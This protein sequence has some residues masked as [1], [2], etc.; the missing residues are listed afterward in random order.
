MNRNKR[1]GN[2]TMKHH[3]NGK[4]IPCIKGRFCRFTI[5]ELLVV[6]AIIAILAGMLLPALNKARTTAQKSVC[7]SNLKSIGQ[8][9]MIYTSNND[10]FLTPHMKRWGW[11]YFAADI[12]KTASLPVHGTVME[13]LAPFPHNL[14]LSI[15]F[16]PARSQRTMLQFSAAKA[17]TDPQPITPRSLRRQ[18]PRTTMVGADLSR[19][20]VVTSRLSLCRKKSPV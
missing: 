1:K 13:A 7:T 9:V 18:A 10:D 12:M 3:P 8:A 6:V 19:R 4:D 11:S 5:I 14:F 17:L 20:Q 16:S 15:K 2:N